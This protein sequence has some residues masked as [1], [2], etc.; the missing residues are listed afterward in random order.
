M[1]DKLLEY[2]KQYATLPL[3]SDEEA[4]ITASFST[5]K[6]QKKTIFFRRR[7]RV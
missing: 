5:Q 3:T 4:L 1:H 6:A 7:Q 2:I